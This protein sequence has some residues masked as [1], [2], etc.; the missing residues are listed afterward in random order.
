MVSDARPRIAATEEAIRAQIRRTPVVELAGEELGLDGRKV[1]LKLEL[2]QH[3]GSFK[4]RGA[5]AN[6][7]LRPVP[8]AGVVAA[9]GG[10][11]GVAVAFAARRRGVPAKIFVPSIC[12]PAKIDRI[13]TYGGD[14]VVGG[15]SYAEALAASEVWVRQSEA[16][17]I[18]AFD[19]EETILGQ[20]T[21]GLELEAQ[22]PGLQT[23]LVGV[24]GGGLLSG[25]ASWYGRRVRLV[26]VEPEGAPTL[27]RAL[28]AGRPVDA[29]VG[30]I[31]A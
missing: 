23:V 28:E 18:H 25:V 15:E 22:A 6:L 2:F 21:L 3:S 16:M 13:R 19:Q 17:P 7:A 12:S 9:S 10:N 24:G 31:A 4:A 1:T 8:P 11:H 5:F 30:S 14:L 29:P 27:T 26:G 20:G